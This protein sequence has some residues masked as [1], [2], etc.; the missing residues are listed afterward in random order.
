[1]NMFFQTLKLI[2]FTV[3]TLINEL[4]VM[5]PLG[6]EWLRL[7]WKYILLNSARQFCVHVCVL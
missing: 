1:M 2:S 3:E 7:H 4:M 5:I 6:H